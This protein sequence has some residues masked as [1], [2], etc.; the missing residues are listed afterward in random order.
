MLSGWHS[1]AYDQ[2]NFCC[3]CLGLVL[4]YTTFFWLHY[5]FCGVFCSI[6]LILSTVLSQSCKNPATSYIIYGVNQIFGPGFVDV[7]FTYHCLPFLLICMV[8]CLLLFSC[9]CTQFVFLG[10]K[11]PWYFVDGDVLVLC[12]CGRQ[13][14]ALSR[15]SFN[16]LI[17]HIRSIAL[18]LHHKHSFLLILDCGLIDMLWSWVTWARLALKNHGT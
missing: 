4:S 9:L 14:A 15:I 12:R 5:F 10:L 6:T 11:S 17:L 16:T 1:Q 18:K 7:Y 2:L 8:L 3:I 13:L